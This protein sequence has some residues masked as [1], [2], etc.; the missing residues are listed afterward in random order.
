M[1]KK[2]I[3]LEQLTAQVGELTAKNK[4]IGTWLVASL[5]L[6]RREFVT[7]LNEG[8]FKTTTGGEVIKALEYIES[9][10]PS[11][12]CKKCGATGLFYST[13]SNQYSVCFD[14]VLGRVLGKPGMQHYIDVKVSSTYRE[15]KR[16]S[17][18]QDQ[19]PR[20]SISPEEIEKHKAAQQAPKVPVDADIAF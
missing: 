18:F 17:R 5:C 1:A 19:A 8:Q 9:K 14:C 16:P 12:P 4:Q 10:I 11:V 2:N 7:N 20:W 3:A 6:I 13:R 15:E